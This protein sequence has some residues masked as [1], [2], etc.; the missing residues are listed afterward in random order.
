MG[1]NSGIEWTDATWNC[2]YGC[3]RVSP[4]CEH[5][6]AEGFTHRFASMEGHRLQGLT[7][8]SD[9]GPRWAN[10]ITL[11]PDRLDQ[12]L[13][14][15]RPRMIFVNSLSDVFHKDVPDDYIMAMFAVMGGADRHQFQLL[16]K[17]SERMHAWFKALHDKYGHPH[18]ILD[19]CEAAARKYGIDVEMGGQ[20]PVQNVWMG[21]SVEDEKRKFRIEHLRDTPAKIR[22]VSAEPLLGDLGA[23]DLRGIHWWIDGG[24]SGPGARPM[25]ADWVRNNRDQV[26][27]ENDRR[28]A[29]GERGIAY[30]M[31]QWGQFDAEG[32]RHRSKKETG[33]EIDGID[34]KQWPKVA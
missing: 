28:I 4:G 12:P 8:L 32:V 1:D 25:N 10:K 19:A 17:R 15:Q 6:Y 3:S 30:F 27:A 24:E 11:A 31:K 34:W 14:W 18:K 13:R 2:I 20:W 22:F 9:K 23:L 33:C 26:L 7:V 5:C 29:A 21:V 16:T